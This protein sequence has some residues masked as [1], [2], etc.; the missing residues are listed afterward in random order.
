MQ[1]N[2][3]GFGAFTVVLYCLFFV[4][5]LP[6]YSAGQIVPFYFSALSINVFLVLFLLYRARWTAGLL[7]NVASACIILM[8]SILVLGGF[9][10]LNPSPAT[11]AAPALEEYENDDPSPL[12]LALVILSSAS[13]PNTAGTGFPATTANAWLMFVVPATYLIANAAWSQ[14]PARFLKVVLLNFYMLLQT[15][16]YAYWSVVSRDSGARSHFFAVRDLGAER[17]VCDR[18]LSLL[19]PPTIMALRRR[20]SASALPERRRSLDD[21][22]DEILGADLLGVVSMGEERFAERFPDSSVMFAMGERGGRGI[23][24]TYP[25]VHGFQICLVAA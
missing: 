11:A 13:G 10:R 6:K 23:A 12:F 22:G 25:Q 21:G 7:S 4:L 1:L 24:L 15:A 8:A 9:T 19:L 5:W 18:I 14:P 2:Y 16:A 17:D 3:V 20:P